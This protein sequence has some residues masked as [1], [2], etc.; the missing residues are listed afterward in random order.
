MKNTISINSETKKRIK[1]IR[2]K[3]NDLPPNTSERVSFLVLNLIREVELLTNKQIRTS[4]RQICAVSLPRDGKGLVCGEIIGDSLKKKGIFNGDTVVIDTLVE[5]GSGDLAILQI[6]GGEV[7]RF[8]YFEKGSKIRLESSNK[9]YKTL[10][11]DL[12]DVKILGR[13]IITQR[14]W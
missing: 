7:I 5:V 11:F 9:D 12:S 14:N 3:I 1:T 10:F 2:R 6:P 4:K 13:V 8:V